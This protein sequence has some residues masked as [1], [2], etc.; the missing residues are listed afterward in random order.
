MLIKIERAQNMINIMEYALMIY[1]FIEYSA[2]PLNQRQLTAINL[3][4]TAILAIANEFAIYY[5]S[6][7]TNRFFQIRI[8]LISRDFL[9]NLHLHQIT[10]NQAP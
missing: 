2:Q 3:I 4:R 7:I 9:S 6:K 5:L 8:C 10:E 1:R